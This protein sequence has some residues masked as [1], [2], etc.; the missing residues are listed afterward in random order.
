MAASVFSSALYGKLFPTGEVGRLWSDSAEV[1]AMLLVEGALAKVQ[2][3]QGVIP[4]LSAA[5]IHRSSLEVQIDP[6]GLADATGQNGVS[7]PA[8]VAEFRKA[9]EAP[10]HAQYAHWG[11]TSQDIIDTALMLRLRQTLSTQQDVFGDVLRAMALQAEMHAET[12]MVAR[13]YGQHATP[14]SWGAVLA[15]WGQPLTDAM[16]EL[17]ALR[18]D[19]LWVSLSGAAG[20]ASALGPKA[21]ETR[22]E[23]ADTLKLHD[24]R[25]SWHTDRGPVMRIADWMGRIVATLSSMGQTAVALAATESQ[26]I[27]LD[28]AG[29]SSTMPQKQNPVGPS[30]L[31][32]LGHQMTGLRASLQ[33]AAAHQHQRDGAAWFTEWMVVPQIAL[34]WA[35]SINVAHALVKNWNP[36]TAAMASK[37]DGLGGVHAEAL[38]FALAQ[39][40]ARPDAQAATKALIAD[41]IASKQSLESVARI[42]HPDLPDSIFDP[43]TQLGTAPADARAFA[44]RVKTL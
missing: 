42:A 39:Q 38:S 40:M 33:A 25:R 13:T 37:F 28:A 15:Q 8:L 34:C 14:T 4:E 29:S 26:E 11:A 3:A 10:E 2:G 30:T 1:R 24:P 7:V 21:N 5:F 9:M 32:A 43:S 23:L 17:P 18:D 20:T 27:A 19:S 12:P 44:N 6:A 16:L 41:A 35:A 36:N 22:A 31:V